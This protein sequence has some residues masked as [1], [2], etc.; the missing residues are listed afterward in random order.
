MGVALFA[1]TTAWMAFAR[2]RFA[3]SSSSSFRPH[4]MRQA[5]TNRASKDERPSSSRKKASYPSTGAECSISCS[6]WAMR[7]SSGSWS[8]SQARSFRPTCTRTSNGCTGRLSLGRELGRTYFHSTAKPQVI[9]IIFVVVARWIKARCKRALPAN[10]SFPV[11]VARSRIFPCSG[12][13]NSLFRAVG[14]SEASH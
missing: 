5:A 12:S 13:S 10:E 3:S 11:A 7:R 1:F 14:N 9:G 6:T 4:Q 8:S 2:L